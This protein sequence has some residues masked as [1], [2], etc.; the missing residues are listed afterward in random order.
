MLDVTSKM[1]TT[2]LSND[3][4][5][6]KSLKSC[7]LIT[8]TIVGVA[9]IV[10]VACAI[11]FVDRLMGDFESRREM[12]CL[13]PGLVVEDEHLTYCPGFDAAMWSKFTVRV[14]DLDEVFDTSRVDTSEFTRDG[15]KFKVDWIDDSWW[16]ADKQ[17]LTGGEDEIG[18][19]F[20]R[21]GYVDN[22]D[23]TMT[24]YIFWFEV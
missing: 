17:R 9:G 5:R 8:G 16:D 23:G 6:K 2:H 20:M 24:I 3:H 13:R 22:G 14:K 4:G 10:G 1:E 15:Y 11:Y 18:D 21:V 7:C 19:D 12:M